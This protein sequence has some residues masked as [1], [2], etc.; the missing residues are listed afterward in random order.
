MEPS[1]LE[2]LAGEAGT[3]DPDSAPEVAV[4]QAALCILDTVGCMLAGTRTE[5]ARLIQACEPANSLADGSD[6]TVPGTGLRRPIAAAM[7]INGY[8]GDVLELNDL[9]GGHSSIGN[10]TASLAL[11]EH[12]GAS[13]E[14][15]L[16]AVMRGIETTSRVYGAVYPTL[17]RFTEMGMVPV[18][19]PSAI[20][21]AA[22]AATL[23]QL[24]PDQVV[25]AMAIAGSLAGWCPAEVIFGQ[26]GTMKP[27]LFGSQPAAAGVTGAL[28]AQRG[29]TGPVHLLD[30]QL[31]YFASSST[32]GRLEPRT[33]ATP[34]ALEQPRR[35]LHACCGYIHS[36]ADATAKLRGELGADII[37]A[38]I[39]V[40]LPGYVM[41]VV[42]K[43]SAPRSANDA[44]FHLPYC[45]ALVA[46]GVDVIL[47]E[48]SIEF[49]RFLAAPDVSSLLSRI[50]CIP[51]E[52]LTHYHQSEVRVLL[53]GRAPV[54][55]ALSAPR[56]SPSEPMDDDAVQEK[57]R[58][59]GTPVIGA[60]RTSAFI[61]ACMAIRSC[62]GVRT[63]MTHVA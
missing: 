35:K 4:R 25:H 44:R 1:A 28:Y 6:V 57:F 16:T 26:G 7:Q 41:D 61:R 60:Q 24:P 55:K 15:L 11:A 62:Q 21:S 23:L 9:I 29:M 51:S 59:L 58:R 12:V 14:H 53:P 18:G 38:R 45:I 48:H 10:V 33:S 42:G 27:L 20:G 22:A 40:L 2:V 56:G 39:Q 37:D 8:H 63:L 30:S 47:P 50:E 32:D 36:A 17:K 31:G 19:I 49:D 46:S 43:A 3:I 13:G 52:R 34:W 5:E 54:S